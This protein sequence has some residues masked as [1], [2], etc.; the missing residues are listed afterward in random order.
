MRR[1][2]LYLAYVA[3][4]FHIAAPEDEVALHKG[5]FVEVRPRS[6]R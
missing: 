5:K 4:H 1:F 6:C 3:T 2:F